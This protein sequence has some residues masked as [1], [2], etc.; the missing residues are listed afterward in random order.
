MSPVIIL[1][2][3]L[4]LL[5]C[6]FTRSKRPQPVWMP[7]L[8]GWRKIFGVTAFVGALLILLNPEFLALSLL[9]DTAFFE[10]LVLAMSLQIHVHVM[11]VCRQCLDG[12]L[13]VARW[14]GVPSPGLLYCVAMLTPVVTGA[15]ALFR[16]L[17]H[18]ALQLC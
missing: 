8:K 2:V 14:L 12:L 17:N 11:R 7:H 6:A 1:L 13:S 18:R 3:A 15:V 4:V 5:V 10:M 9:G 16:R